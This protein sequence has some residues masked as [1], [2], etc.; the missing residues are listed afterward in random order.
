MPEARIE[1]ARG[2][3]HRILSP[4]RLPV[5]PLRQYD[6]VIIN[7]Q[8]IFVNCYFSFLLTFNQIISLSLC[9]MGKISVDYIKGGIYTYEK[10]RNS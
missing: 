5:P 7:S 9:A 1:L 6:L 4:A 3:P 10:S 8:S 2:C